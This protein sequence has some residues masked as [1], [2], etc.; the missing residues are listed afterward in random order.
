M[1]QITEEELIRASDVALRASGYTDELYVHSNV[2]GNGTTIVYRALSRAEFAAFWNGINK[3]GT[4]S[5]NAR[6]SAVA[7]AV[8]IPDLVEFN[9]IV[10]RI[11][12]LP[13]AAL[14]PIVQL[15]GAGD[16]RIE[17][18]SMV[19][20]EQSEIELVKTYGIDAAIL[21]DLRKR[22]HAPGQLRAVIVGDAVLGRAAKAYVVKTPSGEALQLFDRKKENPDEL[23]DAIVDL[24]TDSLVYPSEEKAIKAVFAAAPALPT[25]LKHV[26]LQMAR[27]A[28]ESAGKGWRRS[29]AR[30]PT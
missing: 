27:P 29:S 4:A 13:K 5:I 9:A 6:R 15:A 8:M 12:E 20:N 16:W 14:E 10:Q 23:Y 2:D 3:G 11:P 24:A 21:S 7:D 22:Y 17:P 25:T 26:L 1:K 18:E 28:R 30:S 19:V